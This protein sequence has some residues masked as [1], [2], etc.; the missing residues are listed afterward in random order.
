MRESYGSHPRRVAF[1]RKHRTHCACLRART[2]T[3]ERVRAHTRT[4][5]RKK[6]RSGQD[7]ATSLVRR[8][9]YCRVTLLYGVGGAFP[10]RRVFAALRVVVG[11]GGIF[12]SPVISLGLHV[13]RRDIRIGN[14]SSSLR[15]EISS[16]LCGD[17]E[18]HTR[19][20]RHDAV[21]G[22]L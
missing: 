8:R 22:A 18:S 10:R 15:S 21:V 4:R 11:R 1:L 16:S 9:H 19:R 2:H 20:L 17:W 13:V 6:A 5:T 14:P 3:N 7:D 12:S